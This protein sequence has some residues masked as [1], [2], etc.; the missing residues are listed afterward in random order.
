[1]ETY[2]Y[3]PTFIKL[4]NSICID[5]QCIGLIEY[6]HCKDYVVN[7]KYKNLSYI[8]NVNDVGYVY[9]DGLFKGST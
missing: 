5:L 9:I 4:T 1:M 3:K 8:V 7:H 6:N 2:V